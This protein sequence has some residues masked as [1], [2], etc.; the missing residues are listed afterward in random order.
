MNN[1]SAQYASPRLPARAFLAALVACGC[2]L[3]CAGAASASAP[4]VTI[5]SFPP[6][7]AQSGTFTFDADGPAL[8]FQC[9][10]DLGTFGDCSSPGPLSGLSVASHSFSV[11]AIG[12]DN[13]VGTAAVYTW[14]IDIT[15]PAIPLLLSPG[16]N[17]L[18][19]NPTPT[20]SGTAEPFAHVPV[21]DG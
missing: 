9:K 6:L 1:R 11:R 4:D 19:N 17:L 8:K 14:S 13:W 12:L 2:L 21:F 7:N 5:G 16:D 10:L 18:T 3:A 15:R 20:F